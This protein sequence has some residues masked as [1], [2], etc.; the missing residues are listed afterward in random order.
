MLKCKARVL[1]YSCA[2]PQPDDPKMTAMGCQTPLDKLISLSTTARK[3][4]LSFEPH[5]LT[6]THTLS[7]THRLTHERRQ[8]V[9]SKMSNILIIIPFRYSPVP[10]KKPTFNSPEIIVKYF[11]I[12]KALK[13]YTAVFS[14]TNRGTRVECVFSLTFSGEGL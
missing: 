5:S 7:H 13:I 9:I 8:S 6:Q 12:S 14:L 3:M 10:A 1:N 11:S 4:L 2:C